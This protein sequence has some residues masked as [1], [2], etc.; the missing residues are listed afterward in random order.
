M[1]QDVER[2]QDMDTR[3]HDLIMR[4]SGNRLGRSIIRAIHPHARASARYNPQA[5]EEDIRQAHVGHVAIYEHLLP[6]RRGRRRRGDAGA[7]Q[8][9]V[10]A[11][12]GQTRLTR[13]HRSPTGR[14]R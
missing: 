9:H 11:A 7:H 14:G 5:D 1:I 3:Y 8:R 13:A 4:C 10:D 6:A 12:Q 2:Y